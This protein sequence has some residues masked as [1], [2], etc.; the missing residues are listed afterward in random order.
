MKS[1]SLILAGA[2]CLALNSASAQGC[3]HDHAA[4]SASPTKAKVALLEKELTLTAEQSKQ[5]GEVLASAEKDM[6]NQRAE[7]ASAKEADARYDKAYDRVAALLTA[8]Q[9]EK[10]KQ[11][12]ADGK[13]AAC[14]E[15]SGSGKAGCAG[16][17]G[18]G[19]CCAG[20]STAANEKAH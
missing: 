20:K 16:H 6:P 14:A 19:G 1:F 12:R 13:L 8:E 7:G 10:F 2:F 15:G 17:G 9:A 3:A 18:K 5:V 4:A 11:L